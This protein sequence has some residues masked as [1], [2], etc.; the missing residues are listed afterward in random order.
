MSCIYNWATDLWNHSGIFI[1]VQYILRTYFLS[2]DIIVKSHY[3][4]VLGT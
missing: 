1:K 2:A 3:T 4:A